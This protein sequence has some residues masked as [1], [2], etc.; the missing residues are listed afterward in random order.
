VRILS[1][2]GAPWLLLA[3]LAC[4]TDA[5]SPSPRDLNGGGPRLEA[6]VVN[7]PS[8]SW[9]FQFTPVNSRDDIGPTSWGPFF[10]Y[11]ALLRLVATGSAM[12]QCIWPNCGPAV[13]PFKAANDFPYTG[14]GITVTSSLGPNIGWLPGS[15]TT[16]GGGHGAMAARWETGPGDIHQPY[17]DQVATPC[18]NY[19][20]GTI[21]VAV[22]KPSIQ[23]TFLPDADTVAAPAS[24]V[25]FHV[26]FSPTT[27]EG[28]LMPHGVA[29]W[30]FQP[31]GG[32]PIT[33]CTGSP[34][35]PFPKDCAFNAS[36][37]GDLF[38]DVIAQGDSMRFTGEVVLPCPPTPDAIL[39]TSG[40]RKL[41]VREFATSLGEDLE[42]AGWFY[43]NPTT[44]ELLIEP[45]TSRDR[46]SVLLPTPP[47]QKPGYVLL[48]GFHTH[49]V[50]PGTRVQPG[51]AGRGPDEVAG[52]GPSGDRDIRLVTE[53]QVQHYIIDADEVFVLSPPN[54]SWYRLHRKA[55]GCFSST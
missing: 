3:V 4:G 54:G 18:Y 55:T 26:T 41:L 36:Q 39:N 31:D 2:F 45:P 42:R 19:D 43:R 30:R 11:S 49:Q 46:C 20:G 25:D 33:V 17:C 52:N 27:F 28:R 7:V 32:I 6:A 48:G 40:V 35:N 34:T 29:R 47:P 16:Y 37:N 13:G 51:C 8:S 50:P 15:D 22:F 23:V 24:P 9:S 1:G 12:A 14:I 53:T 5:A 10:T 21:S 44:G 38:A